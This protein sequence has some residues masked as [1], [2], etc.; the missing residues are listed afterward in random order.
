MCF[1]L[2]FQSWEMWRARLRLIHSCRVYFSLFSLC[3][4]RCFL[5]MMRLL[6]LLRQ[7][8]FPA[9]ASFF[10]VFQ[11]VGIRLFVFSYD[12]R[13][14]ETCFVPPCDVFLCNDLFF[15]MRVWQFWLILR[16]MIIV[17]ISFCIYC[18]L[19]DRVVVV[20]RFLVIA[21]CR[22]LCVYSYALLWLSGLYH[23]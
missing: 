14:F 6:V 16:Y 13:K 23:I 19:L 2:D 11:W 9:Y 12:V 15:L 3:V 1:L 21:Y 8:R 4:S 5:F 18:V 20:W 22:N 7:C 17:F 10:G